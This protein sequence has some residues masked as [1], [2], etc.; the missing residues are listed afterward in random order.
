[1][2]NMGEAFRFDRITD[3]VCERV[4]LTEAERDRFLL[5]EGDLL[6]VRQSLKYEG[7]GKCIY[8]GLGKEPRTWE[9]HLIRV[10]LNPKIADSRYY[11]YF[12]RSA[13]GRSAIESIIEQVAAAGIRGSDLR[14][15]VVPLPSREEQEK[16]ADVLAGLDDKIAVNDEVANTSLDLALAVYEMSVHDGHFRRLTS[17]AECAKWYSGGTPRTSEP[18][19]WGGDIPWISALS[20]KLPWIDD[21]DRRLTALGAENGTRLVPRA[22]II[23]VV[24]GSSL[25]GEFRIGLTQREVAF[26]QDCKALQARKGIDPAVLFIAIKSR[27]KEILQLVD[28]AGHGAGR[29]A[30]DVLG[31]VKLWLP[32]EQFTAEA[33]AL[34]R[35]LV[36]IGAVR[37]AENRSLRELRDTLL[38]GFVSGRVQV[39]DAEKVVEEVT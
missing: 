24:R 31:R 29:L 13:A 15:I 3:Q 19:Y 10:R 21:S 11:Y 39:H 35:P 9:S 25:D 38:A 16:I 32:E 30:T 17:M 34:L 1:M 22:T 12:F 36:D 6:F 7:A 28:H 5:R 33:A 14:K 2:I 18:S 26:G 8:V 20:L 37:Q 4:P 27:T 23:F